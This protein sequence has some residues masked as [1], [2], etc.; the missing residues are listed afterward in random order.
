MDRGSGRAGTVTDPKSID[1]ALLMLQANPPVLTKNKDGQVG[2]QKTRYADLVQVNAQVLSRL[3]ALGVVW[4]CRPDLLLPDYRFV[5]KYELRHVAS[6]TAEAG[7]YPL[8]GENAMQQGSAITYARRYAL[9]AVTGIAAEDED[10]DGDSASGRQTAQRAT[11][12]RAAARGGGREQAGGQTAQ[13]AAQRPRGGRPPLP[14]EDPDGP[15]GKDQHGHMRALW[16]D[17]GY[18]GDANRDNRLAITAKIVG[19]PDLESSADLTRAQADAVIDALKE[20][21]QRMTPEA[22]A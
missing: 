13:R 7:V 14:G 4:K 21:K 19:L 5:L 20:R 15:V 3:N 22:D 8:K 9:L 16:R 17:I 12:Q 18:D 2:N 1:E 11:Q 6:G 10:D